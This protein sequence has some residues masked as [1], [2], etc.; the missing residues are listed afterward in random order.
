MQVV[1]DRCC[2][3]DIHKKRVSACRIWQGEDGQVLV[4]QSSFGTYTEDLRRLAEWL[5]EREVYDVALEATG[6]CRGL[7]EAS[8][9]L[10]LRRHSQRY[11]W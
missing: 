3:L 6:P 4:E 8:R 7:A 2:G 9:P 5:A 10:R 1:Y 11:R